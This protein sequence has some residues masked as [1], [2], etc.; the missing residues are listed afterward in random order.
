[1]SLPL[2]NACF[3]ASAA[4]LLLAGL[5]AIKAGRETL[6]ERLMIAASI[7]SAL[8]LAG[9][10]YYH[11]VVIPEVGVTKFAGTGPLKTAY[12]VMLASHVVLAIVNLPM[13][14]RTLFLAYRERWDAHRRL[15]KVTFPIWLYVS[16]TGVLVY[17]AL[18]V[19]RPAEG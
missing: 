12:Y 17:W 11:F 19:W 8:F 16:V 4:V 6:H 10:L 3:N 18:Y 9:Y 5:A 7:V 2:V 14:L 13:V 1:M 15:A